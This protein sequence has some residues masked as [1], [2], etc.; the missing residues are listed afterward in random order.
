MP[1]V[2]DFDRWLCSLG[3]MLRTLRNDYNEMYCTPASRACAVLKPWVCLPNIKIILK[4][5]WAV[6]FRLSS[7]N[8]LSLFSLSTPHLKKCP[9]ECRFVSGD[10]CNNIYNKFHIIFSSES[11]WVK[12]LQQIGNTIEVVITTR[13]STSGSHNAKGRHYLSLIS[14]LILFCQLYYYLLLVTTATPCEE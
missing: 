6:V 3:F 14:R 10:S 8:M 13:K 2:Y 7:N 12:F 9:L 1:P 4:K 5:K 11:I